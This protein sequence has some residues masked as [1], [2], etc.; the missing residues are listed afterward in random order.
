MFWVVA[1]S[2]HWC[3]WLCVCYMFC[4]VGCQFW[5][6]LLGV[7]FII[8]YI[9]MLHL[10]KEQIPEEPL[11]K[12]PLQEPVPT[13]EE[14]FVQDI[15]DQPTAKTK[16]TISEN[17]QDV[18]IDKVAGGTVTAKTIEQAEVAL[19]QVALDQP[20]GD[21]FQEEQVLP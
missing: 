14:V 10:V 6:V 17:P 11:S 8:C 12:E 21:D 19:K 13:T 2:L 1:L 18:G 3:A 4:M 9:S 16:E 15:L 7:L 20:Q 5:A